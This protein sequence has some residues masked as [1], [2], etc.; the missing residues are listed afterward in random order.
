MLS[1]SRILST[2]GGFIFIFFGP[3]LFYTFIAKGFFENHRT[4]AGENVM[5][6]DDQMDLIILAVGCLILAYAFSTLYS[7]WARGAH[8]FS[9]GFEFGAWLGVLG[10]LAAGLIMYATSDMMSLTGHIVDGVW[11]IVLYGIT[12]GI[13]SLIY[14]KTS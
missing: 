3:W 12:G 2:L 13:V 1:K 14:R 9:Q 8:S 5:R 4:L 11:W 7:K 6:P 10:G